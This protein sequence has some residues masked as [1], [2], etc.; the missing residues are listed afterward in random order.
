[1]FLHATF[2]SRRLSHGL[3]HLREGAERGDDNRRSNGQFRWSGWRGGA[4]PKGFRGGGLWRGR[5]RSDACSVAGSDGGIEGKG[6][7]AF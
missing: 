6:G 4:V 5:D 1:M 7:G 2:R 3:R